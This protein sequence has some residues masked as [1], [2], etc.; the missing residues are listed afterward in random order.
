MNQNV[1]TVL[2]GIGAVIALGT[3][4][5]VEHS[6]IRADIRQLQSQLSA[7]AERVSYIQGQL[8][9]DRGVVEPTPEPE[10]TPDQALRP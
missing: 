2:T 1:V 4:M 9:R 7:V 6:S 5:S 3:L 10:A 8:D